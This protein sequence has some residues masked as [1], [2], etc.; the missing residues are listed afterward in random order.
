MIEK[1]EIDREELVRLRA[2]S[3]ELE[4]IKVA[5]KVEAE[6]KHEALM[7]LRDLRTKPLQV[8]E[9]FALVPVEPTRAMIEAPF[10]GKFEGQ[11][12]QTQMRA[13]EIVA[14]TYRAMLAAA[15]RG[16]SHE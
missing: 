4:S 2:D 14:E 15:P 16:D 7:E 10:A 1:V 11:C 12:M 8:P 6:E 9:G 13:R 5:L 3:A